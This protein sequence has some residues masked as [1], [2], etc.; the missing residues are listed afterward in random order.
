MRWSGQAIILSVTRFR[1]HGGIVRLFSEEQGIFAGACRCVFSK[2]QR[3]I[4]E[5]GNL[6][7]ADWS[8]RLAEHLGTLRCELVQP[9]AA[10]LMNDPAKL[11]AL[12][13]STTLL[14]KIL[15]ERDPHPALYRA[16]WA[17]LQE[18]KFDGPWPQRYVQFELLLLS[19]SGFGL[20]LEEC[21][22][23]GTKENLRYV[24]PKSGRAV[25][26]VAGEAYKDRLL[27]LPE[28]LQPVHAASLTSPPDPHAIDDGLTLTGYFLEDRLYRPHDWPLPD[29]RHR[30]VEKLRSLQAPSPTAKTEEP[31]RETVS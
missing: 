1:E 25:C 5:A 9:I 8:A 16:F 10:F 31:L 26:T 11:L 21:A 3:P 19:E 2:K 29:V 4:F 27:P 28:F 20:E 23:T 14:L 7:E 17:L 15:A 22:A 18:M 6:V 13:A 30:L 12:Q 24:S